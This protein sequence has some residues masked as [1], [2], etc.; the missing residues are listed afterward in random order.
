MVALNYLFAFLSSPLSH[1][2][3]EVFD[4]IGQLLL[5]ALDIILKGLQNATSSLLPT[6]IISTTTT[7]TNNNI[8]NNLFYTTGYDKE[9]HEHIIKYNLIN[10]I[11]WI[12]NNSLFIKKVTGY[13]FDGNNYPMQG[14]P[15]ITPVITFFLDCLKDL[16]DVMYHFVLLIITVAQVI[17]NQIAQSGIVIIDSL[18][19]IIVFILTNIFQFYNAIGRFVVWFVNVVIGCLDSLENLGHCALNLLNDLTGGLF[20]FLNTCFSSGTPSLSCFTQQAITFFNQQITNFV[21]ETIDTI[22]NMI[23][24]FLCDILKIFC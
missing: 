14:I 22:K 5:E 21:D 12:R 11:K 3:N 9:L 20:D 24:S 4:F 16:V 10:V 18:R 2:Y 8:L 23:A 19:Q 15:D 17:I 13:Q 1:V 7:T 6:S